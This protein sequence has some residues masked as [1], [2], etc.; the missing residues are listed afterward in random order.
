ME[1]KFLSR[2][3]VIGTSQ[4]GSRLKCDYSR[5]LLTRTTKGNER[6][7]EFRG[8]KRLVSENIRSVE[9]NSAAIFVSKV[10]PGIFVIKVNKCLLFSEG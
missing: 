2:N 6:Q 1:D 10:L 3:I 5:T 8:T 7:S 9:G 4:Y